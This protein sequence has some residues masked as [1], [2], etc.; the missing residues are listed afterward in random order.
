MVD[1]AVLSRLGWPL[2]G[3]QALAADLLAR[4]S[5]PHRSYHDLR[6]LGECIEA[7]ELLGGGRAEALGLWFYD[8]VHTGNPGPDEA[9]SAAL[10]DHLLTPLL[11]A[12][13]VAEVVRLVLVTEHHVVPP[14]DPPAAIVSDA[15]LWVLGAD[16]AR[17]A[18]SVA[19]LKA[20]CGLGAQAWAVTRRGQLL[21]R[22]AAPIYATERGRL[23]EPAARR[24][25]T[26]ELAGLR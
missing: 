13:D 11:S 10:A 3:H 25:L 16:A 1:S 15:D 7:C 14:H 6:H 24:N 22:L 5:E 26:A 20:E 2:P 19:D 17:Y 18:E 9:A 8:A 12:P 21:R 4:W 23:R